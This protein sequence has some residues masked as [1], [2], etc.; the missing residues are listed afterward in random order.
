MTRDWHAAQRFVEAEREAHDQQS[1]AEF[2]P[3]QSSTRCSGVNATDLH[4][5]LIHA[6]AMCAVA[7]RP[8]GRQ[9]GKVLETRWQWS[10]TGCAAT[11]KEN[12]CQSLV[13]HRRSH[14][15][16]RA[17]TAATDYEPQ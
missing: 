6:P 3:R 16:V 9:R 15:S 5:A 2:G 11:D 13:R 4:R 7:N 1:S 8:H 12:P 17:Q 14:A 10:S